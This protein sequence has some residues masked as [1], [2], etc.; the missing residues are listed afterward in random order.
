V[1][2]IAGRY[3]V[4]EDVLDFVWVW[5]WIWISFGFW[6]D[7]GLILILICLEKLANLGVRFSILINNS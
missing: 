2:E 5:I 3:L 4:V 6:F 1:T 7:F